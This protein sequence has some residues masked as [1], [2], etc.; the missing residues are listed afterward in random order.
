LPQ[1]Q[2]AEPALRKME[3]FH[4]D[5]VARVK[6][7]IASHPIVVVGM[8]TNP[9]VKRA[10]RALAAAGKTFEYIEI[11]SY[12]SGWRPRL[13]IKMWSGWPTFPQVFFDGHLVGGADETE[14]KLA[15]DG[16]RP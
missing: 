13:A 4:A 6:D 11:G 16:A 2:I 1:G 14:R 7:A 5:V 9:H 15:G 8:A 12:V 10:R 3:A